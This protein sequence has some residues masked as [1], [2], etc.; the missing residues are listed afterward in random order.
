MTTTKANA[1]DPPASHGLGLEEHPEDPDL[2]EMSQV[3]VSSR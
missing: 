1:S 2:V 3:L